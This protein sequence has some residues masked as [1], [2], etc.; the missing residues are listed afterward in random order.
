[1]DDVKKEVKEVRKE[2][3]QE[4]KKEVQKV[5]EEVKKATTPDPDKHPVFLAKR[6]LGQKA[7]D[8]LTKLA[9]SWKFIIIFILFLIG[10]MAANIYELISRVWDPYPF[11][12]LNFVLSF[13]AALQAP[14]ILMSQNRQS[15][16]DR[17]RSEYDYSVNR[18]AEREIRQLQEDVTEIKSLLKKS[19]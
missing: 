11:I 1:M 2:L 4:V 3:K 14:I 9:G 10:W 5:K 17:I 18:R 8:T 12:L 7:A 19:K 13:L 6:S 15:Q 16:M